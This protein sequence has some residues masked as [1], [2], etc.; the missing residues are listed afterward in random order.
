M[1]AKKQ[2]LQEQRDAALPD[3]TCGGRLDG[4]DSFGRSSTA[5]CD[6]CSDCFLVVADGSGDPAVIL[7]RTF[8]Q[9]RGEGPARRRL[10]DRGKAERLIAALTV[11]GWP[12]P[13]E[14]VDFGIRSSLNYDAL[15][16][17][18][19]LG[20]SSYELDRVQGD[21][22]AISELIRAVTPD[23]LL[24]VEFETPYDARHELNGLSRSEQ[25]RPAFA[26][27]SHEPEIER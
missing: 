13:G 14:V 17:A 2:E 7:L 24:H 27:D 20:V 5:Q 22:K 15:Q 11:D 4:I 26:R 9:R 25:V 23:P 19:R 10:D 12:S 6:Q 18:I 8:N 1:N 3:C 16:S 21:G